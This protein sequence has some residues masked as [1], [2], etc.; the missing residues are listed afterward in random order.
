MCEHVL[1]ACMHAHRCRAWLFKGLA[2]RKEMDTE[3]TLNEAFL[4]KSFLLGKF[5]STIAFQNTFSLA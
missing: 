2:T 5:S 4:G 3:M 1:W